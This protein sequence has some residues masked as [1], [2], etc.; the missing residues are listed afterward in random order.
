MYG[1]RNVILDR[2][3][4]STVAISYAF[5]RLGKYSTF[6][7]AISQYQKL[8][9]DKELLRPDEYIFLYTNNESFKKVEKN[10]YI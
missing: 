5:E 4:L 3:A 7:Y 6:K 10:K 2:C 1:I 9:N 8:F